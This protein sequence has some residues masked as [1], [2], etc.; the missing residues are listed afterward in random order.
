MPIK[1]VEESKKKHTHNIDLTIY[2][3]NPRVLSKLIL[4]KRKQKS[5]HI[6]AKQRS[7]LATSSIQKLFS[8][9]QTELYLQ[10][11]L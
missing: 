1:Y 11:L 6:T 7:N 2:N 8:S 9:C 10:L 5:F 3:V 4:Q